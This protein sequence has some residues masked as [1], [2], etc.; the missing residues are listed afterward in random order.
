MHIRHFSA[1]AGAVFALAVAV[2]TATHAGT[3]EAISASA[4][5][6]QA[7][8]AGFPLSYDF[9]TLIAV[10]SG[11]SFYA[12]L[13]PDDRVRL[14]VTSDLAMQDGFRRIA[15]SI[16]NTDQATTRGRFSLTLDRSGQTI[17]GTAALDGHDYGLRGSAG[18]GYVE[19]AQLDSGALMDL[20]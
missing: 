14:V 4:A 5:S 13:V 16:E 11:D 1:F 12:T 20:E 2:N 18:H 15:G 3:H 10:K 17:V 9:A 19:D 6:M 7:A 8:H